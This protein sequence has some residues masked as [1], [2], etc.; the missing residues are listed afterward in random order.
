[1]GHNQSSHNGG[2]P[3]VTVFAKMESLE[4]VVRWEWGEKIVAVGM[5][6]GRGMAVE[7]KRE[8]AMV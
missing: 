4:V 5:V 6:A 7:R 3:E 1:M 2:D 8:S